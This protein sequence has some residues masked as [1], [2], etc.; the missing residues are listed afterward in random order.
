[1]IVKCHHCG[2]EFD[3]DSVAHRVKFM[4]QDYC[5]DCMNLDHY[6]EAEAEFL[7]NYEP[8]DQP[9]YHIGNH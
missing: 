2:A 1:M 5:L 3:I 9:Y 4:S 8:P 7:A 6:L